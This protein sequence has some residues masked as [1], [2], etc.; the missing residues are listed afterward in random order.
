MKKVLIISMALNLCLFD[1][2]KELKRKNEL[3]KVDVEDIK[4]TKY[5]D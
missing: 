3:L 5:R 4:D 1:K 2:Y